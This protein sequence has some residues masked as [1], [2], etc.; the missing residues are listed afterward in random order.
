VDGGLKVPS[1]GLEVSGSTKLD[2]LTA[3]SAAITGPGGL[4]VE[5]P[6]DFRD[7]V[8]VNDGLTVNSGPVLFNT[9]V[10]A[11]DGLITTTAT[12]SGPL[13]APGT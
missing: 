8:L 13:T 10:N 5:T 1:G 6:A 2:T 11:A 12:L 9:P 7:G 3:L 4:V